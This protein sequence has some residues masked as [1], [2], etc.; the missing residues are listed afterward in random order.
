MEQ[1]LVTIICAC[2]NQSVF[3]IESLESIKKQ[4]YKNLEII[5]WD[6][7]SKD[8]S[9]QKI[10]NWIQQNSDL[11]I[12]FLK[13]TENKGICKSLNYAYSFATGKY[14]QILA[15]D[16]IL[17]ENK[18]EKHVGILENSKQDDAL[19]FTDAYLMNNDSTIY[20][21]KF[22][23]FHK[24]YLSL[25]SG[26]FFED[27]LVKNYIPAM[28]VLYKR[29]VLQKVGLWDE[30]LIF[31]DYDMMLRIAKEHNFIFDDN[32][33]VIYRMHQDNTHKKLSNQIDQSV[34][35]IYQKY[36]GHNDKVKCIL[37]NYI[38]NKYKNNDL[39]GE[40]DL[41]FET[42]SPNGI[43]DKWLARNKNVQ[44]YKV[45]EVFKIIIENRQNKH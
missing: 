34:F 33:S 7:A 41:Y 16:D 25:E 45:F 2:Y 31:E 5:I 38:I 32:V 21:N 36:I 10:E 28:S 18:I 27:L 19:V 20:Q 15:L 1:P 6:D 11:N 43:L 24:K 23:A 40:Q 37:K 13:N 12:R 42:F 30:N 35:R 44:L 29:S 17:L 14:L 3:C 22:I 4:T 39:N 26:N 8:D 9:V